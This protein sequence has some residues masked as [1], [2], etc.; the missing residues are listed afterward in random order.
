[1]LKHLLVLPGGREIFSGTVGQS[2][3]QSVTVTQCVN[4]EEELEPGAVCA[5]MLEAAIFSTGGL[6]LTAGD[7]VT[8]YTVAEDG[9]RKQVGIFLAEK[10]VWESAHVYKLTAY[11]RVSLLDKDLTGWL[12]GLGGWPYSLLDFA[13]MV[14]TACGLTLVNEEIPNAD[15]RVQAF[16]GEGITGRQLMQWVG[17][18]AGR[19]C[20]ATADGQIEF[21]W[22]KPVF[23]IAIGPAAVS[24]VMAGYD[25]EGVLTLQADALT[26][27]DDG[28]GMVSLDSGLVRVTEDEEGNVRFA[29]QIYYYQNS[30]SFEDYQV[31]AVE[32]V[33]IKQSEDDVGTVW[34]DI[35]GEVN[36]YVI[37]G[38]YLLTAADAEALK[39]VAQT[40]YEQLKD[41]TY[42]PCK[43]EVPASA[44]VNA[45][46]IVT[47][48]DRNGRRITAY[49][50]TRTRSGQRDTLECTGSARRDSSTAVNNQSYKALSGKVLNLRTDVEGLKVENRDTAGKIAGLALD[51]EGITA[52]VSRQQ[53]D[54]D[55]VRQQVTSLRQTAE[56]VTVSVQ[57][58]RDNG[59]SKVSNEFGMT[60]D[61]SAVTI[62]RSGSE[63][64]NTLDEK[65]MYVIRS[66][67][68]S[69]EAVML[70]ADA[71]GVIATDVTVR[72]YLV[73][74]DHA[75]FEDYNDGADSKR[76][77]CFFV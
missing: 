24:L 55:G 33:Q 69:N 51:V 54:M 58:I 9:Q 61:E 21:A 37:S 14:C 40:L 65:G 48:T 64:T 22:Y 19:F 43:V 30:L 59:V 68:T 10:P 5:G 38:N 42:T 13:S 12:A 60:I 50:M 16:S 18:A 71:Y 41:V 49:V 57:S 67:G 47:V 29:A 34:P 17:Q 2:A 52:E 28:A 56:Q 66:K 36:T 35:A 70:Q 72:N 44:D 1:M 32:K 4:S 26:A 73:V 3:V 76:T 8:L 63:M 27:T 6:E 45:G 11:D 62:H 25:E 20:R 15:Y 23:G 39:P 31:A 46:D 75:R 7:E 53:T 74:G 77:A